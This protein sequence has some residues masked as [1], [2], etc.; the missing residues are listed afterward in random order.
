MANKKYR[1]LSDEEFKKKI[2]R[3]YKKP[4]RTDKALIEYAEAVGW[5]VPKKTVLGKSP[6]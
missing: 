1:L 2:N 4:S 3:D 5:D 6:K